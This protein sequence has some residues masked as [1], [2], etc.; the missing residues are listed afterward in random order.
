MA[1]K[2]EG[3]NFDIS[4]YSD[5]KIVR[6]R[7]ANQVVRGPGSWIFNNTL[8]KDQDFMILLRNEI[9]LSAEIKHTFDLK[10]DFWDYLK[11]N[12]QSVAL[13]HS[14]EKAQSKRRA[15]ASNSQK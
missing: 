6:F 10:I 2:V 7:M 15:T 9:G 1:T 13:I 14:T 5:H 11:I 4:C 3:T 8:I 12:I